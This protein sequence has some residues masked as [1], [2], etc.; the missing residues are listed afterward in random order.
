MSDSRL[1]G[2][3]SRWGRGAGRAG[4]AVLDV[5]LPPQCLTCDAPVEAPGQFCQACFGE[6]T[7]IT[8]PCCVACGMPFSHAVAGVAPVCAACAADPP[9]W[10]EARAALSYDA[11]SRRVVLPFKHADRPEL[12]AALARLMARAGD[13][14]L[15]RADLLVPVPLHRRRLLA[16][17]YNQSALLASHLARLSG[18]P[19]LPDGL[20]RTRATLPLG[21]LSAAA[22][23]RMVAGAIAV[24]PH[25]QAAIA[26]RHV[27]LVDDVLTSGATAGACTHAL[28]DAGAASVDVLVAARVPPPNA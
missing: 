10:G 15:A 12:A 27:L 25:R 17:R 11:Q 7:F 5:L 24:R 20:C 9:P 6:T 14:L 13:A 18:V 28:L 1:P 2:L 22:R 19:S 16:R 3:L 4:R 21:E 26:G 8:E 23:A